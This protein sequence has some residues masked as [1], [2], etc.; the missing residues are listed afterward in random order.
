MQVYRVRLASNMYGVM[1]FNS[2][3]HKH[4]KTAATII[5]SVPLPRGLAGVRASGTSLAPA[6]H[7][8]PYYL[9]YDSTTPSSCPAGARPLPGVGGA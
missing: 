4:C 2:D 9:N 7:I 5:S 1:L 3:G 8:E 6:S